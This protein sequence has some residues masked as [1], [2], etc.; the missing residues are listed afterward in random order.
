[1]LEIRL[2]K[3]GGNISL[4]ALGHAQSAEYGKDLVCA[5]A[6][7]LFYTLADSL[8]QLGVE[9]IEKEFSPGNAKITVC[10][11]KSKEVEVV[12]WTI[13]QGFKLL[14]KIYKKNISFFEMVG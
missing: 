6:S 9:W 14:E 13:T 8:D 1:M 2:E 11:P 3:K 7:T 4:T 10:D 5:A 12:F